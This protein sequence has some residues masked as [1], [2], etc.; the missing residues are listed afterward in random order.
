MPS[1]TTAT[2]QA[3]VIHQPAWLAAANEPLDPRLETTTAPMIAT[4]NE[5][6]TRR[7]VDAIAAATPACAAG[8]PVTAVFVI[9]GLT[10]PKP[11]P[12]AR[13]A[14]SSQ[15]VAV[16]GVRLV[17]IRP[18]TVG[19]APPTTSDGRAPTRPTSRPDSGAATH[20]A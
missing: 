17:S 1:A 7:L 12:K 11:R 6:P 14:T 20:A 2:P 8:M 19:P 4:P 5:M 9:G 3:N 16:V 10:M 18:A 13:Y 15:P